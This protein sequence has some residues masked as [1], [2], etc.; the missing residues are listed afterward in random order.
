MRAAGLWVLATLAACALALETFS[1][2]AGAGL[3]ADSSLGHM[4]VASLV[5]DLRGTESS[6]YGELSFAG[7]AHDHGRYPEIVVSVSQ[8]KA[9]T[10]KGKLL[11][12]SGPGVYNGEPVTVR[13][14]AFDGGPKGSGDRFSIECA[15]ASGRA[16]FSASG[17]VV[18]GD[19]RIGSGK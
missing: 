1:A 2:S 16:R 12:L 4:D 17:A 19:I 18:S 15:D 14:T 5:F 11:K 10:V 7:E 3:D 9:V 8:P 13:A 6:V